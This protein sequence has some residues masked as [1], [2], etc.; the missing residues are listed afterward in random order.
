MVSRDEKIGVARRVDNILVSLPLH[1]KICFSGQ[2][3]LRLNRKPPPPAPRQLYSN[4]AC[5]GLK[6]FTWTGKAARNFCFWC[7]QTDKKKN[8]CSLLWHLYWDEINSSIRP[9]DSSLCVC[10]FWGCWSCWWSVSETHHDLCSFCA[11]LQQPKLML[12]L[13]WVYSQIGLLVFLLSLDPCAVSR[14]ATVR[15]HCCRYYCQLRF[16]I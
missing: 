14:V 13:F 1:L 4:Q 10:V 5:C 9:S 2:N 15:Q 6:I 12:F 3:S 8:K 16:R 7:N 11:L